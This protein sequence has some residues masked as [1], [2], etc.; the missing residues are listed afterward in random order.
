MNIV[1]STACTKI[2]K[3]GFNEVLNTQTEYKRFIETL[4]VPAGSSAG[5]PPV[6]VNRIDALIETPISTAIATTTSAI[7]SRPVNGSS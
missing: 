7:R 3:D 4:L 1:R 5:R 2:R 6:S